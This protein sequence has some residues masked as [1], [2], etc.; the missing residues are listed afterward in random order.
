M[1]YNVP[2][3]Y[4]RCEC[5]CDKF[6]I[7]QVLLCVKIAHTMTKFE[8]LRIFLWGVA[9][10]LSRYKSERVHNIEELSIRKARFHRM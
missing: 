5:V 3:M 9:M 10:W 2:S 8:N 1:P 4:W 7:S 6:T